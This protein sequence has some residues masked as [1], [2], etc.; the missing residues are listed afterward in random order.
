M[1]L[2]MLGACFFFFICDVVVNFVIMV[3]F[4]LFLENCLGVLFV[5]EVELFVDNS[6]GISYI[7][8]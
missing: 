4:E 7:W 1:L 3:G 5:L 8:Q 2:A 6:V